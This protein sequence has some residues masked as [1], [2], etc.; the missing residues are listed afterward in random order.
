MIKKRY[1]AQKYVRSVPSEENI[2]TVPESYFQS[3]LRS[4]FA[5][6]TEIK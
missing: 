1:Q 6:L 2:R 5:T 4:M 3:D